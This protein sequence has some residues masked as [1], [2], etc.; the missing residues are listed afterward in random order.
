M[1]VA[2]HPRP[3]LRIS[4]RPDLRLRATLLARVQ[5]V[6]LLKMNEPQIAELIRQIES[7]PFFQKLLYPEKP[8]W[9]VIRFQPHPRTRL[10]QS[11]YEVNERSMAADAPADVVGLLDKNRDV[12]AAIQRM[13]RE[14]FERHFLRADENTSPEEMALDC[15]LAPMEIKRVQDFILAFSV[16]SEFF[17]PFASAA[18]GAAKKSA[19]GTRVVRIARLE[20]RPDGEIGFELA[21]P[22]LARGRYDIQYDRFQALAQGGQL[23]PRERRHLKALIRRLE[24]INWRQ[25]ALFRILDLVCHTQRLYFKTRDTLQKRPVT[26]RQVAKRLSVAPS[27]VNRAIQG[28]SVVMPWGEEALVEDLFCSR[29]DLCLDALDAIES[30]DAAFAQK[31]D[32]ELQRQLQKSL[33]LQVPRRTINTYRRALPGSRAPGS[34]G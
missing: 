9:K 32:V 26:Q 19:P 27:T 18:A 4:P 6:Q 8:D 14:K 22:H 21:S 17:D 10:T 24:L 20:V 29:K 2:G 7:D 11:F 31:T 25:N 30:G 12:L 34:A 3:A 33:G 23:K 5:T 13:G 1:T 28:R 15:G 16:Q